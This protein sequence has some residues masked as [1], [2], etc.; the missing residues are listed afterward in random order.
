MTATL[1]DPNRMRKDVK[2]ISENFGRN[3]RLSDYEFFLLAELGEDG[4]KAYNN[5]AEITVNVDY[6]LSQYC[7]RESNE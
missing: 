6:M 3:I 1:P 7:W 2:T 4:V 5:G